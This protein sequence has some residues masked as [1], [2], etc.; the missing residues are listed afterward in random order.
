MT[1]NNDK[2]LGQDLI[3][4]T[5]LNSETNLKITKATDIKVDAKESEIDR[6]QD[7]KRFNNYR[8]DLVTVKGEVNINNYKNKDIELKLTKS[9]TGEVSKVSNNGKVETSTEN[10]KAINKNSVIK[11]TLPVKTK[12]TIKIS[13]IYSVYVSQ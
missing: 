11:W 12:D 2:I 9:V 5:P 6:K 3:S 8:Y 13:Y 1:V 7:A 4:Y 10:L